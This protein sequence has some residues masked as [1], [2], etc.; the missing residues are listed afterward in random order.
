[1]GD[2]LYLIKNVVVPVSK[3]L[4]LKYYISKKLKLPIN[5][6]DNIK[7]IRRSIDARK[8]NNLKFNYTIL[9][10]LPVKYLKN[11]DV[12]EY[13]FPMPYIQTQQNHSTFH[14]TWHWPRPNYIPSA[15]TLLPLLL[16]P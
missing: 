1:M 5:S 8:K 11:P 9:T 12:L 16:I 3:K 10:E 4:D 2:I 6:I 7:V 14:Q 13:K 15:L